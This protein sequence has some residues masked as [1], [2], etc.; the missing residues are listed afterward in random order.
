MKHGQYIM[1]DGKPKV[2]TY[3]LQDTETTLTSRC[4]PLIFKDS[5]GN[6]TFGVLLE[7]REARHKIS[8][9]PKEN[10]KLSS[11]Y[12][13][14]RDM[15]SSSPGFFYNIGLFSPSNT[16]PYED[17]E[18]FKRP[19][20]SPNPTPGPNNCQNKMVPSSDISFGPGEIDNEIYSL[21]PL[22]ANQMQ[23][24]TKRRRTNNIKIT[25]FI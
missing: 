10:F 25:E 11:A 23:L 5:A 15:S 14:S 8:D 7:S 4:S 6:L 16:T 21:T 1:G 13:I 2:I 19:N 20:L 3:E 24:P 9:Q 17:S 22:L 18:L 12:R